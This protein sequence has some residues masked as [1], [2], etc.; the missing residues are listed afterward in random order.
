MKK[1]GRLGVDT[2]YCYPEQVLGSAWMS[3]VS[4]LCGV[5][6]QTLQKSGPILPTLQVCGGLW[7]RC[8]A[9]WQPSVVPFGSV[10]G[11]R[12]QLLSE[13]SVGCSLGVA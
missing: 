1:G 4:K 3:D 11:S 9:P 7:S 2:V 8:P 12:A 5:P 6:K 10:G 13:P